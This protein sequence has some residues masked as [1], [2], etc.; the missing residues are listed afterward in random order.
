[1]AAASRAVVTHG[2]TVSLETIAREAGVSK[3]GL[4]HHFASK[5]DL[6][7]AA[8]Q[9][10]LDGFRAAVEAEVDPDDVAPGRLVR[11]YIRASLSGLTAAQ[12]R[13]EASLM[14]ALS[15][16]PE[17]VS[18]AHAEGTSWRDALADDGLDP[19]RTSVIMRATDGAGAAALFEGQHDRDE[20]D[21]LREKLL[22]L[23]RTPGPL[24]P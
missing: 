24:G 11:A 12:V 23:T 5:D 8:A 7:V 9:E 2:A 20:I 4:L 19:V 1:M 16:I 3:G 14:A 15:T 10:L 6:F 22:E 21:R 18:R 13:D 17:V